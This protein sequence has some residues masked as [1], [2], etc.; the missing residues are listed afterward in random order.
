MLASGIPQSIDGFFGPNSQ[1][2]ANA[3]VYIVSTGYS[4][5]VCE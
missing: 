2:K 5:N 4:G 1:E 3:P